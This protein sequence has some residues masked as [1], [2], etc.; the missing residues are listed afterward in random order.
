MRN[1][2]VTVQDLNERLAQRVVELEMSDLTVKI[3]SK[4]LDQ[5]EA[6]V[7]RLTEQV[8]NCKDEE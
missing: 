3:M 5:L 8:C 7:A 2:V 4:E 6:E 1:V